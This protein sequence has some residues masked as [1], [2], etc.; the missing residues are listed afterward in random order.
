MLGIA[1]V[2]IV[3]QSPV[4]LPA[5]CCMVILPF[6]FYVIAVKRK[7]VKD[8]DMSDRSE[9]PRVLWVLV[10]IEV[11]SMIIFQLWSLLPILVIIIGFSIITHYWKISG[12]AMG[13][14]LATGVILQLF[15]WAWWPVLLIVPLV[16]WARVVR[17][18]HTVVQVIAGALYTFLLLILL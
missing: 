6:L 2:L 17:R 11:I 16:G 10:G 18:D 5:F 4:F 14:A 13:I 12:H 15:G 1:F 3:F 8:W 7:I 9:R